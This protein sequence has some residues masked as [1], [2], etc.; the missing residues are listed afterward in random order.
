MELARAPISTLQ[1]DRGAARHTCTL[2]GYAAAYDPESETWPE[3]VRTMRGIRSISQTGSNYRVRCAI[4]WAL[5]PGM[6]AVA[7]SVTFTVAYINYYAN[8]S[9]AYMDI[10]SRV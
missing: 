5:R 9:D 2:S 7:D 6:D 3:S 4:D 10:G 8:G 1:S